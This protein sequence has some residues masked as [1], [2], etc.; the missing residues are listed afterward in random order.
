MPRLEPRPGMSDEPIGLGRLMSIALVACALLLYEVAVTRVLS[1]VLWYHFAFLSVSLAMLGVGAPGVW[2][3]L[4]PPGE[5]SLRFALHAGAALLPL[6]VI[7]ILRMRPVVEG[8]GLGETP[9][10]IVVVT[11]VM[12][13]MLALGSA[14]CILLIRARG[15]QIGAM[16]G[17]DL[18]GAMLGALLTPLFLQIVPTPQL[19]ALLSLLPLAAA[20]IGSRRLSR[21]A[22]VITALL[23]VALVWREPFEVVYNKSYSEERQRPLFSRWTPT[24]R[25]TL[26]DHPIW[27]PLPDFPWLWGMGERYSPRPIRQMWIDQDGSA[28]MPIERFTGDPRALGYLLFDV[29]SIGY[30]WAEP[31]RVCVIGAGGGR[32]VLTALVAGATLVDAVELNG[33]IVETVSGRA[34]EFS[35]DVYHHRGVRAVISEGRSYLTRAP[36]PYDLV[37]I[38]LVDSWAATAAG[39]YALSE[40]FL[41]TVEALQLYWSRLSDHGVVS[42]SRWT[43]GQQQLEAARLAHLAKEALRRLGVDRPEQ[44]MA[45]VESGRVGT[46]LVSRR[47]FSPE[48]VAR[49]DAMCEARGFHRRWPVPPGASTSRVASVL[50]EGIG[51]FT[52]LGLDFS[53]PTDD[54]P[55]FFQTVSLLRRQTDPSLL[56]FN[57]RS[58]TLLRGVL[59]GLALLAMILF[60]V[61]FVG[62]RRGQPHSG[63]LRGSGYFAA[64]GLGFMCVEMPWIQRSILLLGHPTYATSVVLGV[65]LLGAGVGSITA[66]KLE[67]PVIQRWR[68]ALPVLVAGTFLL[69]VHLFSA[70]L[71]M[72]FGWRLGVVVSMLL[73]TGWAMGFAFPS[74]IMRFGDDHKAWFWAINGAFGV[75]AGALS[76]ALA[77]I[78]GFRGVVAIGLVAYLAAAMLLGRETLEVRRARA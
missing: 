14:I 7:A 16:Y 35:G 37:Q 29:T 77:M 9:W 49:L 47:A 55:F 46:L 4:R 1:V 36:G 64:I 26:F 3:A 22:V 63:L 31:R 25:I 70:T 75:F 72:A 58:V 2:F 74:G 5:R 13:P 43:G 65:L 45:F 8:L 18:L 33:G 20:V 34:H 21:A 28:G 42:I 61:P 41:Y 39:A 62:A 38:S 50:S 23:A 40:N 19:V 69:S 53:P 44:H 60:F 15:R 76:L 30:E 48:H 73:P 67:L 71:G 10:V 54:R 24:A 52:A 51:R 78:L 66:G 57:E 56:G 32:D 59:I 27:S 6:S 68:F 11:A 17:A 12:L